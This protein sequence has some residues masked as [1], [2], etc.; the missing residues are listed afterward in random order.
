VKFCAFGEPA[1]VTP[2]VIVTPSSKAEKL[3]ISVLFVSSFSSLL[4]WLTSVMTG[5]I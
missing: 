5:A 1:N 4:A 2:V 3:A